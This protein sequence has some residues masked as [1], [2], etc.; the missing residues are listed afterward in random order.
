MNEYTHINTHNLENMGSR[1][2]RHEHGVTRSNH[3]KKC[4]K[5]SFVPVEHVLKW[6]PKSTVRLSDIISVTPRFPI[7]KLNI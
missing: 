6:F 1:V 2:R 5:D 7:D 4:T 3:P